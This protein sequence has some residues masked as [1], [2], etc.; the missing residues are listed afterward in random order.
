MGLLDM[1]KPK[2]PTMADLVNALSPEEK[3]ALVTALVGQ[4]GQQSQEGQQA[5]APTQV[6]PIQQ[7]I[8]TPPQQVTPPA[9]PNQGAQQPNQGQGNQ[10]G[11][12]TP[13]NSQAQ[14]E[15]TLPINSTLPGSQQPQQGQQPTQQ[16]VNAMPPVGNTQMP[17]LPVMSYL[18][19]DD[20]AFNEAWDRGDIAK[21]WPR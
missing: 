12:N 11:Q 18:A 4:N 19:L 10:L 14:G 6:A 3:A 21:V 13:Q 15:P 7:T 20:K 8:A 1:L 5:P 2:E 9:Q 16:P 17:G